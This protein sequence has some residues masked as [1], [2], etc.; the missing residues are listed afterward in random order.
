MNI[1]VCVKQVPEVTDAELTI[2][3]DGS[4]ILADDLEMDINEWDNY[5]VETAVRLKEAHGGTVTAVTM[6]DEDS[7]D[8]LRQ[9]LAMGADEA[10]LIDDEDFEGS[11]A[12]G[13]ARGLHAAIKDRPFDLLLAGVQSADNGWGQ[14]G[15]VLAE[16]LQRP[17]ASLVVD[18][19]V[20]GDRL[21]VQR[22]L[23]SNTLERVSLPLPA[24]L[25]IQSGANTPRYVSIL[26]IRRVRNIDIEETDADDLGLDEDQIGVKSSSVQELK[27]SLP[28]MGE[29]AEMLTGS[30][31]EICDQ[32][33][34]IIREKGGLQ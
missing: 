31:E 16:L 18:V 34:R 14:V 28:A 23:E 12:V 7:E 19:Q 20:D 24:V 4:R 33:A 10:I 15:L 1:V 22:E 27:L 2:S 8:V 30:V 6:G 17:Y 25:T 5:A 26:G 13:I 21:T 32:T 9:A 3:S 29:G 11:D